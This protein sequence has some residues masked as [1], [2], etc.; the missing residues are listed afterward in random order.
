MH[1]EK[2]NDLTFEGSTLTVNNGSIFKYDMNI[3]FY[4]TICFYYEVSMKVNLSILS[5]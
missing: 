3:A 2:Y 4:L 1:E 5:D